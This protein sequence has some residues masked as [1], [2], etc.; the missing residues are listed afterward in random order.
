MSSRAMHVFDDVQVPVAAAASVSIGVTLAVVAAG[1]LHALWN[2]AAHGGAD[3]AIG[4]VLI[5][6]TSTVLGLALVPWSALP[7]G[8]AWPYLG[9]SAAVHATYNV[10]LLRSYQLGDF[11]Q[12]YPLARGISPLVVGVIAVTIV[13]QPLPPW[14]AVGLFSVCAGLGLVAFGGGGLRGA[15]TPALVA[16]GLT[17]LAIATYTVLDG[18]GVRH[19]HSTL[20]YVAWLFVLQSPLLPI[21]VAVRR[22]V[23][24]TLRACRPQLTIGVGSGV[25][26]VLA[27]GIV[28][29][30][31]TRATL[32]SVAATREVSILFGAIIG[33]F[34]FREPFGRWR[35]AG[36]VLTV[37]GIVALN[38]A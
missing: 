30:A 38:V 37:A 1:L 27:Y 2:A 24:A 10:L 33:H 18:V 23:L 19:A 28:I 13:G 6:A 21:G 8:G 5:G 11:G 29:W 3:R 35:V 4:F 22:G 25:V 31:Q 20:G 14:H 36:A 32:A 17:G 16:A 26:S 7:A 34:A 15:H 12:T 9:C